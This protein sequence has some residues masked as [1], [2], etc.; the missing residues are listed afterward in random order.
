MA[1][2]LGFRPWAL[3]LALVAL[4]AGAGLAWH[5]CVLMTVAA[6]AGQRLFLWQMDI[7][8]P[9]QAW[10]AGLHC[11][12][13]GL[14]GLLAVIG[15]VA[16]V[17]TGLAGLWDMQHEHTALAWVAIACAGALITAVQRE[18][19]RRWAEAGFWAVLLA[20]AG[21]GFTAADAGYMFLPCFVSGAALSWLAWSSWQLARNA[22][23]PMMRAGQRN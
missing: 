3:S 19:P 15:L 14:L 8:A 22:G 13:A 12:F 17:V 2:T 20:G 1:T 11:L 23:G 4:L 7:A 18:G 9:W 6:V 10:R 21:V 16:L 5:E